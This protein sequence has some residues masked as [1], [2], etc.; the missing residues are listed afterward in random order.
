[1]SANAYTRIALRLRDLGPADREWL[2]SQLDEDDCKRVSAA[3]HE[4]RRSLG[5]VQTRAEEKLT[6]ALAGNDPVTRFKAANLE[7]VKDLFARQPDWAIAL[8]LSASDI[9]WASRFLAELPPERIR[10]LRAVATELASVKPKV[11]EVLLRILAGK[12]DLGGSQTPVTLA[13]DA[14]LERAVCGMSALD[15]WKLDLP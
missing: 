11:R 13:F 8:V 4:H 5:Q 12:F 9:P 10:R 3:L 2:L 6:A 7:D 1:M 15:H 14:A